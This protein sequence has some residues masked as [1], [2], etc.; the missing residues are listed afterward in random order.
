M[1][2]APTYRGMKGLHQAHVR[3]I[4]KRRPIQMLRYV[5]VGVGRCKGRL[6]QSPTDVRCLM[7]LPVALSV[8]LT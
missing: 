1:R 6:K 8:T 5:A 3:A 4:R 2:S 7:A